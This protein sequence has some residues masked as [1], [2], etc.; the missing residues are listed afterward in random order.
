MSH[1]GESQLFPV[2]F[3]E[4]FSRLN[5]HLVIYRGT[6][7]P[8]ANYQHKNTKPFKLCLKNGNGGTVG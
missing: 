5:G 6:L 1:S 3:K 2:L 7:R 4:Q 8:P